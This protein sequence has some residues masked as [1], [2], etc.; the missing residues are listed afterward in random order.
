MKTQYLH[1]SRVCA[2]NVSTVVKNAANLLRKL[3]LN[4]LCDVARENDKSVFSDE[5]TLEPDKTW[6]S[7]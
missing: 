5:V 6:S 2:Q 3:I 1:V 4:F 7:Y